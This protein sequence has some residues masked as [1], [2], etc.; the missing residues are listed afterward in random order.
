MSKREGKA[1]RKPQD[2]SSTW[3]NLHAQ[4]HSTAST[5]RSQSFS[6][7]ASVHWQP[8]PQPQSSQSPRPWYAAR[9]MSSAARPTLT[10]F[11]L[12][13]V[14]ACVMSPLEPYT[15]RGLPSRPVASGPGQQTVAP[16]PLQPAVI[17]EQACSRAWHAARTPKAARRHSRL[18][19][20]KQLEVYNKLPAE[21]QPSKALQVPHL[22]HTI[23]LALSH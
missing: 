15:T 9:A 17:R 16:T 11:L 1:S 22:C 7:T 19:V 18:E 2:Y 6:A 10:R 4:P 20:Y 5:T 21:G 13:P 3:S 14:L 12:M 23:P 8:W